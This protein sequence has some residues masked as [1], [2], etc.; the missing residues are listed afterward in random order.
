MHGHDN[1]AIGRRMEQNEVTASLPVFDKSLALEETNELFGADR[2]QARAH[3]RDLKFHLGN[4][5][6]LFG[7]SLSPRF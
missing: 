7:D 2:R 3:L 1:G 6:P 5:R 4:A